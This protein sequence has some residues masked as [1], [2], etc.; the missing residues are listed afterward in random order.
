MSMAKKCDICGVLYE[1]YADAEGSGI[2]LEKMEAHS[3]KVY[4]TIKTMDCCKD[5]MKA[6]RA[7]LEELSKDYH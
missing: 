5:C 3:P 7:C 1:P 4:R 2:S 6:I